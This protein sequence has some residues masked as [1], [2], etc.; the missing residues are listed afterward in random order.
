MLFFT[1]NITIFVMNKQENITQNIVGDYMEKIIE[2]TN[3]S[4]HY[5]IGK[6]KLKVLENID[7]TV[8]K[9]DFLAITGTSGSG[10]STLMNILG[11]LDTP[12]AGNYFF[13]GKESKNFS[14]S[15]LSKLRGSK[16]GFIFQSFYLLPT[17]TAYQN[18]ELPLIY[19]KVQKN[20]RKELCINALKRV[21]LTDRLNH[22]PNQL[23]GGQKQRVAI[24]RAISLSP[25]LILADEPT[26]NLDPTSSNEVLDILNNL[27][28]EGTTVVIITHDIS[29]AN[30]A[31]NRINIINGKIC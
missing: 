24:A 29:I 27:N 2:L 14:N 11:F 10:K 6:E 4:K 23:S 26:G 21:G 19:N 7:L 9:G 30:K 16:I 28:N 12:D 5:Y 8:K 17:L 18:V 22:K 3:I 31:K 15:K 25:P 20:K 1:E 13:E